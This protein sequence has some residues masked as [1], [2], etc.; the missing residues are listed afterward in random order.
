M[1]TSNSGIPGSEPDDG[2]AL[3]PIVNRYLL[4]I[5]VPLFSDASGKLSAGELWYKDL[6]AHLDYLSEFTVACPIVKGN[7]PQD[8]VA[9]GSDDRY[10]KVSIVRLPAP[11]GL[12]SAVLQLP[13]TLWRLFGAV[14][15]CEIVHGGIAGWPYP[16]G[17]IVVPM[18][19]LTGRRSM[20]IV[21][22]AP[23]RIQTGLR[24]SLKTRVRAY[25]YERLARY[26]LRHTDLAIFTQDEYRRSLLPGKSE[27]GHIIHASWI[28]DGVILSD[29]QA[30]RSWQ[31]K[32]HNQEAN[33]LKVLFVGRLE[34]EKGVVLLLRAIELLASRNVP[35]EL[36]ILGSGSLAEECAVFSKRQNQQTR[37]QVLGTVA[38][39]Q[40]LFEL[41][42]RYH[43][44]VV[45]SI[46]DE[47]P[48]IIYDAYSQ[49]VPVLATRTAGLLD[50]VYEG[51]TG[52]FAEVNDA[53]ALA[54]ALERAV[55][56]RQSLEVM[57]LQAVQVSR[58]MTHQRMH[59]DR[60][61]LLLGLLGSSS[62]S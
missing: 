32:I 56:N 28:D 42:R 13:V 38:Y 2:S 58:T 53:A 6:T 3:P 16:Y 9:L 22:S 46:S 18:A 27:S 60:H 25:V 36:D 15:N 39:G 11:R 20:L 7:L 33:P 21:E 35:I 49:A 19:R 50:C 57:G 8:A 31:E 48:R 41:I 37:V 45:P 30:R 24:A 52:W 34:P 23:W 4:V 61:K 26:C 12:I 40:P 29:E 1:N 44:I 54:A 43:A 17:W 51:K 47:Q 10:C 62:K 59:R 55:A 14:R 5:N